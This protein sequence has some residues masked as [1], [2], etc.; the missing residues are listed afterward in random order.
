MAV[1]AGAVPDSLM[2]SELFGHEKGAFTCAESR[3]TCRFEEAADGTILL[4]EI[5]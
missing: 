1:P 3:R 4:D 2:Q 5:G